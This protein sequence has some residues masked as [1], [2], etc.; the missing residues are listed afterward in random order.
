LKN[1]FTL[2]LKLLLSVCIAWYFGLLL[3]VTSHEIG[4]ATAAYFCNVSIKEMCI[5]KKENSFS[6]QHVPILHT[7]SIDPLLPLKSLLDPIG[8]QVC[9]YVVLESNRP[10]PKQSDLLIS[11]AG[12]VT[13]FVLGSIS[14]FFTLKIYKNAKYNNYVLAGH[15][16][17]SYLLI[18]FTLCNLIPLPGSDMEH[19]VNLFRS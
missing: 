4:H 13:T 1:K 19:I 2:F 5:G 3:S 6:M 8:Q 15:C 16:T 12:I 11:I 14:V 17:L 10:V 18:Y 7:F 9:G